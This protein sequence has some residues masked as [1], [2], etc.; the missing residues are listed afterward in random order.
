MPPLFLAGFNDLV[1]DS[2]HTL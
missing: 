2:P 1:N